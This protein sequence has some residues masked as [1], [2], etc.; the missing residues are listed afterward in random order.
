MN[1]VNKSKES[2]CCHCLLYD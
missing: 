1:F 2:A